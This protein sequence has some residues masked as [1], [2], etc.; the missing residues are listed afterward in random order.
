VGEAARSLLERPDHVE[1]PDRERPYEGGGLKRL[2]WQV[3]LL[4]V[5]LAPLACAD[6]FF[7]VAQ[8]SRP[9]KILVKGLDD[10]R[11]RGCMVPTYASV[12]LQEEFL[13]L[14]GRD[15]FHEHSYRQRAPLVLLAIDGDECLGAAGD[16]SCL[17]SVGREDLV[18]EVGQKRHPP[19]RVGRGS[20]DLH[21][22]AVGAPERLV[23]G[24][25]FGGDLAGAHEYRVGRPWRWIRLNTDRGCVEVVDEDPTGGG[26]PLG[27]HLSECISIIIVLSRDMMQLD[28]SK[29]VLQFAHLQAVHVHEGALTVGLLH[30]LVHYQLRVTV[31]VEPSGPELDSNADAIDEA[32]VFSDVV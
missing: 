21:R 13:A 14:L 23:G 1:T 32:L 28:S 2:C 17:D 31:G 10:Q 7:R 16:P 29:L 22:K 9:V 24:S 30:D 15:A 12:D 20:R 25:L 6:D 3:G 19:V 4:G 27:C 18:E 5:E 11:L 26:I 8:C